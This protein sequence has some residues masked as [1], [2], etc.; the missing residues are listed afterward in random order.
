MLHQGK[1]NF[2]SRGKANKSRYHFHALQAVLHL[3]NGLVQLE[4]VCRST[5]VESRK[6][7]QVPHFLQCA[8]EP[9]SGSPSIKCKAIITPFSS[10]EAAHPRHTLKR[11]T[12]QVYFLPGQTS[13]RSV[14]GTC[15]PA[16]WISAANTETLKN[17]HTHTRSCSVSFFH[18]GNFK[19]KW[20]RVFGSE[21]SAKVFQ[22]FAVKLLS[23][24]PQ[25]VLPEFSCLQQQSSLTPSSFR[26]YFE[27]MTSGRR[28]ESF[29]KCTG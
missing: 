19:L 13:Q 12:S 15:H 21:G 26:N 6:S 22:H 4:Q 5:W 1:V 18:V 3:R 17:T 24:L 20:R 8:R 23:P 7:I 28:V 2:S 27:Q 10:R 9:K 14:P 11:R 16:K 25:R 29:G